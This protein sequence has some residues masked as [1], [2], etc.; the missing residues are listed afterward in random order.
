MLFLRFAPGD[1]RGQEDATGQE[2]RGGPEQG[3]LQMP[4][5][6]QV[7]GQ[8]LGQV[9]AEEAGQVGA[10]VLT[11][12]AQQRLEALDSAVDALRRRN[13]EELGKL[14]FDTKVAY[15]VKQIQTFI[16]PKK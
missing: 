12:R 16:P 9:E 3:Q 8:Q 11:E 6:G 1:E 2:R 10:V 15:A 13:G 7:V 4:G 5:A 14:M